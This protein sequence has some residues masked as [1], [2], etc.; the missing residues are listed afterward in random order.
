MINSLN[1]YSHSSLSEGISED[2]EIKTKIIIQAM[3]AH[4]MQI[5]IQIT[6]AMNLTH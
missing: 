3:M 5:V 2:P 6:Q 1:S 4:V